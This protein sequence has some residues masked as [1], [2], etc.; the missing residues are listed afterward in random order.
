MESWGLSAHYLQRFRS[1]QNQMVLFVCPF[2]LGEPL[3]VIFWPGR[4]P[5]KI[6]GGDGGLP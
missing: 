6:L 4:D 3:L 2:P 5:A 1:P